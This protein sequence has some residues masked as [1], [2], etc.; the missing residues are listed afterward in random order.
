MENYRKAIM[1]TKKEKTPIAEMT[2]R[3]FIWGATV[4]F[5][6]IMSGHVT[7]GQPCSYWC[8]GPWLEGLK[9]RYAGKKITCAFPENVTEQAFRTMVDKF[10]ELTGIKVEVALMDYTSLKQKLLINFQAKTGAFDVI[11]VDTFDI[12]GYSEA[13]FI[14]DLEP[15]LYNGEELTPKAYDYEDILPAYRKGIGMYNGRIYG[16]PTVG[17]TRYVAYRKDLFEENG[18]QPPETM[19]ELLKLAKFFREQGMYGIAIEGR[20]GIAFALGWMTTMYQNGGLFLDEGKVLINSPNTVASLEYYVELL[21][22]GPLD[23]GAEYDALLDFVSGNAAMWFGSTAF[24]NRILDPNESK[25]FDKVEFIPPPEGPAGAYGAATGLNLGIS[26][27]SSKKDI[28]WAFIVWMTSK[29]AKDYVHLGGT[30]MRKF[31]YSDPE[32]VKEYWT[33]PIQLATLERAANLVNKGITWIPQH[34]NIEAILEV[35]GNYGSKAFV[36]E[37]TAEEAMD[38]AQ[39][40]VENIIAQ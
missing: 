25:V 23:I 24:T 9:V 35:V 31:V 18:L 19:D 39:K 17:T 2:R 37:M 5:T 10:T 20:E 12:A 13:D 8:I 15:Y 40:E 28:A 38:N 11:P 33:F 36:G 26:S 3:Q 6:M 29:N 21:R 22:Q 16:I 34:P 32:L 30:P 1:R 14:E 7:W 4:T 27:N